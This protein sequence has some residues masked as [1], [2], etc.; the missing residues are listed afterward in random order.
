MS[1][2][3]EICSGEPPSVWLDIS[4]SRLVQTSVMPSAFDQSISRSATLCAVNSLPDLDKVDTGSI[5]RQR[6]LC[7]F[8]SVL[9]RTR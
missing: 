2:S 7:S 1:A 8:A 9:M 5:T 3:V 6:A 4:S